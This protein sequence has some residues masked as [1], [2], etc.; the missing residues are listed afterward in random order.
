MQR[1]TMYS[2]KIPQDG[3]KQCGFLDDPYVGKLP[4][5]LGLDTLN[6]KKKNIMSN[7]S[8]IRLNL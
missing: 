3:R 2:G 7:A 6:T 1:A 4:Y 8:K 5:N